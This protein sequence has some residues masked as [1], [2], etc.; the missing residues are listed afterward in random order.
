TWSNDDENIDIPNSDCIAKFMHKNVKSAGVAIYGKSNGA[1]NIITTNIRVGSEEIGENY[2]TLPLVLAED[3]NVN[4]GSED[5]QLLVNFPQ[6][7]I[8]VRMNNK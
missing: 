6:N 3:F 7:K 1:S 2:H 8:E 4:F 5:G